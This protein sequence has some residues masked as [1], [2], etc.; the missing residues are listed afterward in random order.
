M[1]EEDESAMWR[2]GKK[3]GDAAGA[4]TNAE[5]VGAVAAAAHPSVFPAPPGR[6]ATKRRVQAALRRTQ[7]PDAP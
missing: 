1:T 5:T 2:H 4:P 7:A 3:R 6:K